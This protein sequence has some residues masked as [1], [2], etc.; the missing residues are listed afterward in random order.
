MNKKLHVLNWVLGKGHPEIRIPEFIFKAFFSLVKLKK[1]MCTLNCAEIARKIIC[2]LGL[3]K[4]LL[5]NIEKK[6]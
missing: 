5:I 2:W 3:Q 6:K 1:C 4:M